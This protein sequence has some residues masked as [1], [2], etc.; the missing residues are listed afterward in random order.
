MSLTWW[1]EVGPGMQW[2]H[3][4]QEPQDPKLEGSLEGSST[5]HSPQVSKPELQAPAVSKTS[6]LPALTSHRKWEARQLQTERCEVG[7]L[8][9]GLLTM[10]G[11]EP[12]GELWLPLQK[13][14]FSYSN[15]WIKLSAPAGRCP[16]TDPDNYNRTRD[17]TFHL[18]AALWTST[19]ASWI[20]LQALGLVD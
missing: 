1:G 2:L 13:A 6:R 17:S 4:I 5:S 12:K 20:S 19:K 10:E 14:P 11:L 8:A 16:N 7:L 18:T 9:A 15:C 3:N